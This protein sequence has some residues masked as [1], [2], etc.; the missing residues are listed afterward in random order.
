MISLDNDLLSAKSVLWV[1]EASNNME[2][3]TSILPH[4]KNIQ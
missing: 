1:S 3:L 2:V 4:R